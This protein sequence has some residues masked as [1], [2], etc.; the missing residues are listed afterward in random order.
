M[1]FNSQ[2]INGLVNRQKE[3]VNCSS[4]PLRFKD[5]LFFPGNQGNCVFIYLLTR[6]WQRLLT[7]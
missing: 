4:S 3:L 7:Y 6:N 5:L 2:S 1:S